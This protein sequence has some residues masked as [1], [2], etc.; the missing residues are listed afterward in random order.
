MIIFLSGLSI[1][2]LIFFFDQKNKIRFK[3][4]FKTFILSFF[5]QGFHLIAATIILKAFIP[6]SKL[7]W[8][9]IIFPASYFATI[10]PISVGGLG[11]RESVIS[12]IINELGSDLKIGVM[13]SLVIYLSR[14]ITGVIGVSYIFILENIKRR[15]KFN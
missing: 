8:P 1:F 14:I 13:I 6:S 15:I 5:A 10:I 7:F 3:N 2:A 9:L 12:L 4:Y 11:V